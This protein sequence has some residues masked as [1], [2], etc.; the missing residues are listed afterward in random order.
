MSEAANGSIWISDVTS[1]VV[2]TV[3]AHG[4]GLRVV[5]EEGDGPG[6]VRGPSRLASLPSG[7]VSVY[8]MIRSAVD[9]FGSDGRFKRRIALPV[10]VFNPKGF[11]V[12]R[13]GDFI[14]SGGIQSGPGA[15]HQFAPD[16][17][18]RR[19]WGPPSTARNSKAATMIAGGPVHPLPDGSILFSQS[20][21]HW[22]AVYSPLGQRTRALAANPSLAP[23]IGDRFVQQ[24]NGRRIFDWNYPKSAGVFRLN[25]GRI[26]NVVQNARENVTIWEVYRSD[27][28]LVG[29]ARI[30][31]VYQPWGIT[32][33]GDV[34]ASYMDP[35][36]DEAVASRLTVT[37]R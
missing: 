18:L 4:G 25:D 33:D 37:I 6:E 13:S 14:L 19:S 1:R 30:A 34:L 20:A 16:G 24:R 7:E 5:A 31:R 32:R 11:A 2:A 21:P 36:T 35:D 9:V 17:K 23:V 15:I 22:I 26:V 27:G 12:L 29:R 28:K 8:D 10:A 3:N